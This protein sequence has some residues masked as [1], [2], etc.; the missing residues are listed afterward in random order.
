MAYAVARRDP[1]TFDRAR[2]PIAGCRQH[3]QLA[4][5]DP[6]AVIRAI[7]LDHLRRS[8]GV[9]LQ[10]S[11]LFSGSIRDNIALTDP[12][13]PIDRVMTAARLAGAH[14]FILALP[15]GYDTIVEE[16]GTNFSGGQRQR[17]AIARA[18][19]KNAPILL[20][21]EATSALDPVSQDHLMTLVSEFLP[22]ATVVSVAHRPELEA[23]HS[24]KII[25]ER[26]EGGARFVR[27]I[28][29]FNQ[30]R[31]KMR[32]GGLGGFGG[33]CGVGDDFGGVHGENR[34]WA[35]AMGRACTAS[36]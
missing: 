1:A 26:N 7:D 25:L 16:R 12:A 15:Q 21:D 28:D 6:Q 32:Q 4:I 33:I 17:L 9:V 13:L 22:N 20:L 23:F 3:P 14:D 34:P 2:T 27:D 30:F 8:T 24:R 18:L 36:G 29:L 19:L 5:V 35:S 31:R 11:F 10:E